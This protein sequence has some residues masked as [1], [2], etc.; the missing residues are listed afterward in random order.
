MTLNDLE[1]A[2]VFLRGVV[3]R[4]DNEEV[5][6]RTVTNIESYVRKVR[7]DGRQDSRTSALAK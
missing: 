3:A 2:L 1:N 4:G 6:V 7:N 5:L